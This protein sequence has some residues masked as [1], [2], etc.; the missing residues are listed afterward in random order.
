MPADAFLA[1]VAERTG[2][3]DAGARRAVD[4]VLETLAQ[5]IAG[6]EVDDLLAR[7]PPALHEPLKRG[8]EH[9]GGVARSMTLARFL[10]L[11]AEREAV[12]PPWP[13]RTPGR[14]SRRCARQSTTTSSSA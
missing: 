8:R 11:I 9:S 7:L 5:R 2:L 13:W 6:G 1:R 3:D 12:L 10:A 4:A 14:S